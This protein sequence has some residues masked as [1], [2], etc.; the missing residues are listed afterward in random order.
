MVHS[1]PGSYSGALGR[2]EHEATRGADRGHRPGAIRPTYASSATAFYR[3]GLARLRPL[4][5]TR[6]SAKLAGFTPG[7]WYLVVDET[8]T[9]YVVAVAER[10][11]THVYSQDAG[12]TDATVPGRSPSGLLLAGTRPGYFEGRATAGLLLPLAFHQNQVSM[13]PWSSP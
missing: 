1:G 10:E 4:V 13:E 6:T 8:L 11:I 3:P 5:S 9:V 2:R 12:A 7:S